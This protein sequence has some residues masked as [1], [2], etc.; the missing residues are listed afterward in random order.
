MPQ[1]PPP[2]GSVNRLV[3]ITPNDGADNIPSPS[4]GGTSAVTGQTRGL[5]VGAA[6]SI[7]ITFADGTTAVVTLPAGVYGLCDYKRI[8]AT[9]TTATPLYAMVDV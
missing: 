1:H 7:N 2:S 8:L 5:V 3:A 9:S 4:G 6:G